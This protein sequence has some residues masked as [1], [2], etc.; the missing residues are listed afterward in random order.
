MFVDR[1]QP[2]SS[3]NQIH[4]WQEKRGVKKKESGISL[5]K[6]VK[7]YTVTCRGS[8]C[9]DVISASNLFSAPC[10]GGSVIN[11]QLPVKPK[12]LSFPIEQRQFCHFAKLERIF[13]VQEIIFQNGTRLCAIYYTRILNWPL[14]SLSPEEQQN[15]EK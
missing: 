2:S 11:H 9:I 15:T 3:N 14:I 13:S 1:Q 4:K 8:K 6:K 5:I 10:H 12:I 7:N